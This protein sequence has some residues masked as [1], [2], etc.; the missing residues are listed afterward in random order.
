MR[1]NRRHTV[2]RGCL[3]A[4]G[5]RRWRSRKLK[6]PL[7]ADYEPANFIEGERE[8]REVYDPVTS[9]LT[10]ICFSR[11]NCLHSLSFNPWAKKGAGQM[12]ESC[13]FGLSHGHRCIIL[14]GLFGIPHHISSPL[15]FISH[16]WR[17]SSI[18]SSV[19]VIYPR[20]AH[21]PT[22]LSSCSFLPLPGPSFLK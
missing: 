7:C 8:R 5:W 10:Q 13:R 18:L 9:L 15:L 3:Q 22:A 12:P 17:F 14:A 2:F 21:S 19:G 20:E 1:E 4:G 11:E 16:N 6:G